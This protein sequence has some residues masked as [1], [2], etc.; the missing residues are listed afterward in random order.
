MPKKQNENP[1]DRDKRILDS[2]KPLS[3][4]S[5]KCGVLES[6]DTKR[7]FHGKLCLEARAL[8]SFA[9]PALPWRRQ[10]LIAATALPWGRHKFDLG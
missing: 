5:Q 1:I 2:R 6:I 9:S 4:R 3:V 10:T 8:A 7:S